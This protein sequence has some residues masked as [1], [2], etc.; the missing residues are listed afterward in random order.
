MTITIPCAMSPK[1][2]YS[3]I[4]LGLKKDIMI[5]VLSASTP[6]NEYPGTILSV[7]DGTM[8]LDR[9]S[10]PDFIEGLL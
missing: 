3:A 8:F 10:C 4:P 5:K 2:L 6:T 1:Y 7:K 9:N